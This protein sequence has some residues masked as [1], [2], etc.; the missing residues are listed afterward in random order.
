MSQ[1]LEQANERTKLLH[2][3][4]A[5]NDRRLSAVLQEEDARS[6]IGS[7]VSK[8]EQ[9]LASAPV[10]ERLPYN[11]YT[12]IDW[13]HDLVHL[14]GTIM[15]IAIPNHNLRSKILT[16]LE[17]YV[18]ARESVVA[19]SPPSI[20]AQAGSLPL[21]SAF[22]QPALPSSLMLPKL[23]SAIGSWV[24]AKPTPFGVGKYA[25]PKGNQ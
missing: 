3:Y 18:L 25:V 20:P 6:F 14:V 16:V 4:H 22:L 13:L 10:G 15:T 21:L 24:T 5:A 23:P 2:S 19:S 9:A 7:H 8:D 12:T 17:Q 11:D 1:D